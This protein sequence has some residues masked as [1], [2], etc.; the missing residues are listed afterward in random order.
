MSND[1]LYNLVKYSRS[2]TYTQHQGFTN[3]QLMPPSNLPNTYSVKDPLHARLSY[4][5]A[6]S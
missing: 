1:Q 2:A 6:S 4:Q 5:D 3:L